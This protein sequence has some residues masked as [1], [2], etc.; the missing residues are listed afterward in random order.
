ARLA[1]RAAGLG[2]AA[3]VSVSEAQPAFYY[4]PTFYETALG[5]FGPGRFCGIVRRPVLRRDPD[6]GAVRV[7]R[8]VPRRSCYSP[9]S[10]GL[11]FAV[12]YEA[13]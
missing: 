3:L 4:G 8:R 6:T 9:A 7:V 1:A 10:Y 2:L 12:S 5:T 13:S 11:R